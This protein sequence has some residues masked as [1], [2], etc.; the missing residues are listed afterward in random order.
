MPVT[1]GLP[2]PDAVRSALEEMLSSPDFNGSDRVRRFLRYVVEEKLEGRQHRIKA[3]TI[4]TSVFGRDESFDPQLDSIVRIEAGRVRQALERYY[5]L[6]GRGAQ[7]Q[8]RIPKGGYVPSFETH[9]Y[10]SPIEGEGAAPG[11]GPAGECSILVHPLTLEGEPAACSDFAAGLTRLIVVS[12]A[13]FH[14]FGVYASQPGNKSRCCDYALSGA[15]MVDGNQAGADLVLTHVPSGRV[16]WA[17]SIAERL[18]QRGLIALRDAVASEIARTIGEPFGIIDA[19]RVKMH[20]PRSVGEAAFAQGTVGFYQYWMTFDPA[21]LEAV[22][23]DLEQAVWRNP[24]DPEVIA[25]LSLVNSNFGRLGNL[26]GVPERGLEEKALAFADR[27]LRLAPASSWTH[28]ALGLA[29]WAL[30]DIE[31]SLD[32]LELAHHLNPY[33][34]CIAADLGQRYAMLARWDRASAL[35]REAVTGN[36]ALPGALRIGSFLHHFAHGQYR[37]A[38]GEARKLPHHITFSFA[39]AAAAAIRLGDRDEADAAIAQL[40]YHDPSYGRHV[41]ADLARRNFDEDLAAG[42]VAAIQ[43]AGLPNVR[44]ISGAPG[45]YRSEDPWQVAS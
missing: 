11:A 10:L 18:D 42:L 39:A 35:N 13:R 45:V 44:A 43:E 36:P 38:L 40:L 16:V 5:L 8:I 23:L 9:T 28:Y 30:R 29:C 17:Y 4:A 22:Q 34:R 26:R 2:S 19:D 1:D 32:A 7:L 25:C 37:Q 27:A 31:G 15:T 6:E 41:A 33:D 24:C 12:L 14:G 20:W 3:Y 21:L